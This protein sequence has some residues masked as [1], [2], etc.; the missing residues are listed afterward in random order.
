MESIPEIIWTTLIAVLLLI[1]MV[2]L[3]SAIRYHTSAI[4]SHTSSINSILSITEAHQEQIN[5]LQSQIN[6]ITGK[7]TS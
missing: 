6:I 3:N 7:G 5:L 1:S 4:R 2:K